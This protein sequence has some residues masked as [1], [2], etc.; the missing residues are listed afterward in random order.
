MKAVLK[1]DE[2]E[3]VHGMKVIAY[4]HPRYTLYNAHGKKIETKVGLGVGVWRNGNTINNLP[5]YSKTYQI[6]G[7]IPMPYSLKK[8]RKLVPPFDDDW[9]Y[10]LDNNLLN[11]EVEVTRGII[12]KQMYLKVV[13]NDRRS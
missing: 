10:I 3:P 5:C 1:L 4:I 12:G 7:E 11:K 6:I 2:V 9:G 8:I 13:R